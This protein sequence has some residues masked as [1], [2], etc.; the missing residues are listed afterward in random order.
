MADVIHF[1]AGDS[2]GNDPLDSFAKGWGQGQVAILASAHGLALPTT[3]QAWERAEETR[4]TLAEALLDGMPEEVSF[5]VLGSLARR[6]MTTG[7]DLD[8]YLL[9]DGRA[10]AGQRKL[11]GEVRQRIEKAGLKAPNPTGAFG[12][13]VFSHELIHCIGGSADTN[14]NLTRRLLLLLESVELAPLSPVGAHARIARGI[15]QRYFEEESY[16]PGKPFFPRFFLNDVVRFWRTMAVDYAAKNSERGP[17][18]WALRNTKLRF[19]RKLL[20]VAGLLL[21]YESQLFPGGLPEIPRGHKQEELFKQ[22]ELAQIQLSTT[23]CCFQAL[24]LTPLEM[25]ARVCLHF[26]TQDDVVR[27]VFESYESFLNILEDEKSR[28]IL[29]ELTFEEASKNEIFRRVRKL[30]ASFQLG[31]DKLFLNENNGKLSELTKK[32]GTF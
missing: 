1:G 3:A 32:Y 15:L 18:G 28:K 8:W 5:V 26:N 29:E 27:A 23:D 10:D 6:E 11:Q 30:G 12:A 16:F 24:R 4:R 9:V 31:L 25:L 13:L 19:S 2:H 17:K 21:S 22:E 7:S 14:A 20:F